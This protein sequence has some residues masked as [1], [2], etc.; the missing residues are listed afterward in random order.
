MTVPVLYTQISHASQRFFG[1][2]HAFPELFAVVGARVP[3]YRGLFLRGLGGKSAALGVQQGDTVKSHRHS[4]EVGTD[5]SDYGP[6]VRGGVTLPLSGTAYTD[7][8]GDGLDV[9]TRPVNKAVR[10][11]IRAKL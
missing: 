2:A 4:I 5:E 6:R 1:P 3:D 7:Y 10:Y 8:T 9:E 11:L